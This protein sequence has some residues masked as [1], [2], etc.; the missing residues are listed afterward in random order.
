MKKSFVGAWIIVLM[1]ISF[2]ASCAP[3]T[4]P[5]S[6]L[7]ALPTARKTS[8]PATSTPIPTHAAADSPVDIE[9]L[10]GLQ[11]RFLHPWTGDTLDLL[12][13]MVDQFN[14]TNEWGIHVIMFA[15]GSAA[16]VSENVN[17]ELANDIASNV[18]VA[19][20]SLL[21][22][23]DE[24]HQQVVNLATYA[25]SPSYG[26]ESSLVSDFNKVF[27]NEG[28]VDGKLLGI[29]AQ[30][31]ALLLVYNSTWG[32]EL[33]FT[34]MPETEEDFREQ[35]CV[36]NASFKRDADTTNDGLGGW[37][38]NMDAFSVL[39][40]L[41]AFGAD[42]YST[43]KFVF[44]TPAGQEALTYLYTLKADACAW[45]NRTSADAERFS[46]REALV[47]SLWMQDLD[48]QVEA[49]ARAG[50]ED[51]WAVMTYPGGEN[52]S[53]LTQGSSYAVLHKDA[54]SDLAAWL[55][56]RWL[57]QPA[58]QSR[59]LTAMGT[60]PLG[61]DVMTRMAG[62]GAENPYWLQT[63]RSLNQFTIPPVT[64]DWQVIAPVLEDAA[65][66]LWMGGTIEEGIPD[67]LSQM[68]DLAVE[69]SERYP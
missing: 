35:V 67:V 29:P 27:W 2:L 17:E 49:M 43:G 8:I 42:P 52:G 21:L 68:D 65:W 24:Q 15:P 66:Q 19:P 25:A 55:F 60:L 12:Y 45:T 14:Q 50:S 10:D 32:K 57:A 39:N 6:I 5:T 51:D 28:F 18:L 47:Y 23:I 46:R 13:Q 54:A 4:S 37:I 34:A 58:Q 33:G 31:S 64:A 3:G 63:V 30:R 44:S 69:L 16:R 40:W 48:R 20:V 38:L 62:Y 41:L 7:T 26:M 56:I 53:V 9:K 22:A 11:I 61:S 1:L 59:L 36:A